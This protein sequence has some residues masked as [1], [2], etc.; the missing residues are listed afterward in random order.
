MSEER[1][2][3]LALR[4]DLLTDQ[5]AQLAEA[6]RNLAIE[7]TSTSGLS[8]FQLVGRAHREDD[9]VS[10]RASSAPSFA[11]NTSIYNTLAKE[12][13]PLPD[14]V[15]RNCANL[16]GGSLPHRERA[17][18]AWEAGWW[19]RF[20]LEGKVSKPRPTKPFDLP[21]TQYIV[22][23][24]PGYHCPLRVAKASDYRHI[25]Q[26]FTLPTLSHGFASQSEARAYCQGAGVEF[27]AN[28]YQWQN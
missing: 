4:L 13:P 8:S 22:L 14:F 11:S 21:N 1:I 7:R 23:R 3:Q 19:A 20:V 25:V 6:V 15:G 24:A 28:L 17:I 18:R 26:D 5:V 12:I 10:A 16:S 9:A 27:P 2:D